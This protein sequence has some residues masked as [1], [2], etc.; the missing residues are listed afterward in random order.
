M[1]FV[2]NPGT[3]LPALGKEVDLWKPLIR[4]IYIC[5]TRDL[6]WMLFSYNRRSRERGLDNDNPE[7]YERT[8]ILIIP[9]GV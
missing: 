2:Y 5:L 1:T 3:M 7:S 8:Q 4:R 9:Y 6:I